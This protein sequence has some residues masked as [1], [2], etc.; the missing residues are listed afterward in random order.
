MKDNNLVRHLDACETMG[1]ATAICSDKT[2]YVLWK[3]VLFVFYFK[4]FTG[5]A[6]SKIKHKV[7]LMGVF[8]FFNVHFVK[9]AS[10]DALGVEGTLGFFNAGFHSC[11]II[12]QVVGCASPPICKQAELHLWYDE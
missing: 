10:I 1:N 9:I 4:R 6:I 2:G 7:V 11:V 12:Y 3:D 8:I 5:R